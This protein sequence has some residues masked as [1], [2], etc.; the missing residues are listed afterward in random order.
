[1]WQQYRTWASHRASFSLTMLLH[2][3]GIADR[4]DSVHPDNA[5]GSPALDL[6]PC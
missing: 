5:N 3:K 4:C 2:L 6:V 1:M